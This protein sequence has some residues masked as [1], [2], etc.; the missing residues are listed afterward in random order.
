MA[1]LTNYVKL[2]CKFHVR[3]KTFL[4]QI[5]KSKAK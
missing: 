4:E 2:V 1:E 3:F 5:K